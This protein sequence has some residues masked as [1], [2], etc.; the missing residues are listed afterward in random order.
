MRPKEANIIPIT[1]F[2]GGE[3]DFPLAKFPPTF[4]SKLINVFPNASGAIEFCPGFLRVNAVAVAPALYTGHV[5]IKSDGTKIKLVAGDGYIFKDVAGVLTQIKSGLNA[6][7][8]VKF[9]TANNVCIMLNGVDVPMA[10]DGTTVSNLAGA[11]ATA[12]TGCFHKGRVWLLERTNKMLASYSALYD[13]T[14][15]TTAHNAGY[16]D[17]TKILSTGDELVEV[18]PYMGMLVFYFKNHIAIYSGNTPTDYGDFQLVQ[19]I[20]GAGAL[21]GTVADISVDHLFMSQIGCR[22]LR[23][24][25]K[26]VKGAE[27]LVSANIPDRLT[28]EIASYPDGPFGSAVFQKRGWYMALIGD[29]IWAY[30]IARKAWFR[31]ISDKILG[32]FSDSDGSAVYFT[33]VGRLYEF[34][35]GWTADGDPLYREWNTAWYRFFTKGNWAYPKYLEIT[36]TQYQDITMNVGARFNQNGGNEDTYTEFTTDKWYSLMDEPVQDVWENSFYMDPEEYEATRVPLFGGGEYMQLCFFCEDTKGPMEINGLNL[37]IVAG[38]K[39]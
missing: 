22:S 4:S 26:D 2:V 27:K 35:S 30:N 33:G 3:G 5:F 28:R 15:Y 13:H 19:I 31:Y 7:A 24:V 18:V 37:S 32:L 39:P 25:V 8:K 21:P 29:T 11:P 9:I 17:F 12:F 1:N 6:N 20:E 10:Y 38:G 23:E 34:N 36:A 14:D 16:Y